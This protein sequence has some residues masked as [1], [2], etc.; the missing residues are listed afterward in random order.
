MSLEHDTTSLLSRIKSSRR[1]RI[2]KERVQQSNAPSLPVDLFDQ[3][4]PTVEPTLQSTNSQHFSLPLEEQVRPMAEHFVEGEVGFKK[5]RRKTRPSKP[6]SISE[7]TLTNQEQ[8]SSPEITI[9][10][11][12]FDDV[13]FHY[14]EQPLEEDQSVMD[15]EQE[16]RVTSETGKVEFEAPTASTLDISVSD[17]LSRLSRSVEVPVSQ[18]ATDQNSKNSKDQGFVPKPIVLDY[19]DDEG[20]LLS[21]KAAYKF[22]SHK[23]SNRFPGLKRKEREDKKKKEHGFG[24]KILQ[25]KSNLETIKK[26]MHSSHTPEIVLGE[27]NSLWKS[28]DSKGENFSSDPKFVPPRKKSR[29]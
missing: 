25:E 4:E 24:A 3:H 22:L 14:E 10:P 1:K 18:D 21:P 8:L 26:V 2:L 16:Q 17:V 15:T 12:E 13:W 5:R 28:F 7:D 6:I 20:N 27:S 9:K 11:P 29:S 19:Y 23:F